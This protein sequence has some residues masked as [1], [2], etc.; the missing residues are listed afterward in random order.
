VVRTG[1][2]QVEDL[3][4]GAARRVEFRQQDILDN[5]N[6]AFFIGENHGLAAFI[7]QANRRIGDIADCVTGF[8][9]GNDKKYLRPLTLVA[10]NAK[11]YQL[12]APEFIS[13]NY[14]AQP[15]LLDGIA[16]PECYVPI[17]KGGKAKYYKPDLWCMEW[18]E[19]SVKHYKTDAK[20]RFQN[21][22]YY[23]R[24][25]LGVPMVTSGDI[26][27]ALIERKLFDQSIVGV[28]PKDEAWVYYLLA[29]FNSPICSRL[30]RAINPSANNSANYIKKIPFI[31]PPASIF[32]E[33]TQLTQSIVSQIK[34]TGAYA[35]DSET[36]INAI[37][38]ELY[39][40]TTISAN[41]KTTVAVSRKTFHAT[42]ITE[43]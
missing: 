39:Q 37:F 5:L 13:Q 9:S 33:V 31:Q 15:G 23:F 14:L 1:F 41:T 4:N 6:H 2:R 29:F 27:A 12:L 8:Y 17:V 11:N 43:N 40:E 18:S 34:A 25:G 36:K 24:F 38:A 30:I 7:N 16:G 26:S 35:H 19:E 3:S 42:S 22:A 10:K 28:F 32:A 20:A 21:P